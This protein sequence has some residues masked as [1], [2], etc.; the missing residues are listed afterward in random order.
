VSVE[1]PAGADSTVRVGKLFTVDGCNVY[2]FSDSGYLRYFV[3]CPSG[4]RPA[5]ALAGHNEPRGKTTVHI[6]E[7]IVTGA[8]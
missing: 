8:Q 6:T 3:T 5:V 2:R 4:F 1:T 7:E